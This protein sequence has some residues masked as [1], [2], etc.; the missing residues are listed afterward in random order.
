MKTAPRSI[1]TKYRETSFRSQFEARFAQALDKAQFVWLYE[2]TVFLLGGVQRYVPDFRVESACAW[3][4]L[5]GYET[6]DSE[7]KLA[8]FPTLLAPDE[9]FFVLGPF[10]QLRFTGPNDVP[11]SL[12][13]L[14]RC[15]GEFCVNRS[16]YPAAPRV[17]RLTVR[18]ANERANQY[19]RSHQL[20]DLLRAHKDLDAL[21]LC[22]AGTTV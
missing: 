20:A 6:F 17:T 7:A 4:E 19:V 22:T 15:V 3:I 2:P 11:P 1:R 21:R 9:S 12:L 13:A 14:F 16:L 8:A 10:G 18:Q 5:R